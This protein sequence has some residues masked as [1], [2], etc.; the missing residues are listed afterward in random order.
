[1]ITC[2]QGVIVAWDFSR[3][4]LQPDVIAFAHNKHVS[5]Q[6]RRVQSAVVSLAWDPEGLEVFAADEFGYVL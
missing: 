1:V 4:S 3:R 2:L 6:G 5:G